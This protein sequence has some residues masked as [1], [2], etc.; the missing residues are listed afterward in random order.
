M[1]ESPQIETPWDSQRAE[2]DIAAYIAGDDEAGSRI[3]RGLEPAIRAEVG[4]FLPATDA[5]RDD[6]VQETLLALLTYLR[7]AGRCPDR[8][9]AFV[10]TMAGNRCRN[11][12]RRRK[13]RPGVELEKTAEWLVAAGTDPLELLE[14]R[15]L[16]EAVRSGLAELDPPCRQ[17]LL[18]I[19]VEQR[20]MEELQREAGLGTVQGIYYRK[21]ACLKKLR[22]SLNRRW[23]G[24]RGSG[25]RQ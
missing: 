9:G 23:F 5:E 25:R 12:Y 10:V 19:Y 22:E 16:E 24:G 21:Y 13:R 3:C 2:D 1:D 8:P 11:L 18:A 7:R 15:E 6:V 4:R 20:P 14:D 17:L